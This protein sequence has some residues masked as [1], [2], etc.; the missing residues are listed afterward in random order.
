MHG[1]DAHH[2]V[3]R[4]GPALL[5]LVVGEGEEHA[6][7]ALGEVEHAG[8]AEGEHEPV[9]QQGID[10]AEHGPEEQ[11]RHQ[12]VH[13]SPFCRPEPAYMVALP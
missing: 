4:A 1:V 10:A 9:G 5:H 13:D 3:H 6:Q 12:R 7:R 8:R 2:E 11:G